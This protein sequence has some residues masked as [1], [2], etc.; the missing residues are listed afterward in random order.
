MTVL[1]YLTT[2]DEGGETVFP[3]AAEKTTGPEWSECARKGL[4]VKTYRGDAIMFYGLK[5]DGTVDMT[6]LHGSCPTTAGCARARP[7][8]PSLSRAPASLPIDERMRWPPA[9]SPLLPLRPLTPPPPH[10]PKPQTRS[11]KWSATKWIHV[12]EIG[13]VAPKPV[14]GCADAT[15]NCFAW[16]QTGECDKNPGYM[17]A[18]CIKSCKLCHTLKNMTVH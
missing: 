14:A 5:P 15:S 11:E 12:S 6:S 3:N 1:M 10:T 16:A 18:N 13:G 4:A 8:F 17:K 2:P 7:F 9:A